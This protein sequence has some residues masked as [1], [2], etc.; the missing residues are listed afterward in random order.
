MAGPIPLAAPVMSTTRPAI[1]SDRARS[2]QAVWSGSTSDS[3][4][5]EAGGA[6][7]S[8]AD[9]VAGRGCG[10]VRR[11]MLFERSRDCRAARQAP[12]SAGYERGRPQRC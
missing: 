9:G 4:D 11:H 7:G 2:R 10:N 1:S 8:I 3:S 6:A 12:S 5:V